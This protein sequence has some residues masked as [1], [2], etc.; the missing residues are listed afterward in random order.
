MKITPG[1]NCSDSPALLAE[2][3]RAVPGDYLVHVL[4]SAGVLG[5]ADSAYDIVR[6]G[7]MLYGASPNPKFQETAAPGDDVEDAR[8]SSARGRGG[9]A[10]ISYGRTFVAPQRDAGG[11]VE[12]GL[13]GWNSALDFESRRGGFDRRPALPGAGPSDDGSHDGGRDRGSGSGGGR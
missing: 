1:S 6:A 7:L 4:P 3:R 13:R 11:D 8:R 9:N 2:L 10:S 5:F 12:R